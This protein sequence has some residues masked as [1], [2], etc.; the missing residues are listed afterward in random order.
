ME[1][2]MRR[3]NSLVGVNGILLKSFLLSFGIGLERCFKAQQSSSSGMR[4]S[5]FRARLRCARQVRR[6]LRLSYGLGLRQMDCV[7]SFVSHMYTFL[8]RV[9]GKPIWFTEETDYRANLGWWIGGMLAYRKNDIN[10]FARNIEISHSAEPRI[11]REKRAEMNRA[12]K[13]GVGTMLSQ[14]AGVAMS[15]S[16]RQ[17]AQSS[18][19]SSLIFEGWKKY[20]LS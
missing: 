1:E 2:S 13:T 3:A 19:C 20:S 10:V 4:G 16:P 12:R 18:F 11:C 6:W 17:C 8:Q 14:C 7:S 5:L 15:D 9:R